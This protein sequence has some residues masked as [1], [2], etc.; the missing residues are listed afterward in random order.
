MLLA[1]LG[2][3]ERVG[4]KYPGGHTKFG[5]FNAMPEHTNPL[6]H[7]VQSVIAESPVVLLKVPERHGCGDIVA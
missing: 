4:Q 1:L 6:G 2:T 5:A 3:S 7:G